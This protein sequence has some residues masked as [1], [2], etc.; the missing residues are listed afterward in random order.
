M[1]KLKIAHIVNQLYFAG[2]EAGI[3]KI[4]SA[5]DPSLFEIDIL[6]LGRI[7]SDE[8]LTSAGLRQIELGKKPGNDPK[9]VFRL[10]RLL[11]KNGYHIVYTH[12]WNTLLEG[13]FAAMLAGTPVKIHGEHGTFEHSWLKDRLQPLIWGR[14]DAVTTVAGDLARRMR[15]E[16]SY[17]KDNI[18]ILYNGI[19]ARI[20][21]PCEEHRLAFRNEYGVQQ[22]FVVGTVGRFHPV[23]DHI[24]LIRGFARFHR[25]VPAAR[26]ILVGGEKNGPMQAQYRD[27]IR[28]CQLDGSVLLLPPTPEIAKVING[29]DVFALSSR[30]E[31]CSNVI[32]EALACGVPVLATRVGGNPELIV[33]GS[34]GLLFESG[35]DEALDALLARV[36]DDSALRRKLREAGP[37]WVRKCFTF[38]ATIANYRELY[39]ELADQA[40]LLAGRARSRRGARSAKR[41]DAE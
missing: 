13:Y 30:S 14:F 24:T 33:D 41:P 27:V 10:A 36:Y 21:Y 18:R 37:A 5:L 19:D 29:F 26:L 15:R 6:V 3:I 16:F 25:R 8:Q 7:H 2:K 17:Q 23:K 38:E 40:R 32:L 31:G 35:D 9:I 22:N 12:A 39:L 1:G 11:R 4:S 28:E 34:N 20:F